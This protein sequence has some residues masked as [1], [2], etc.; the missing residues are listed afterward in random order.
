ME[1]KGSANGTKMPPKTDQKPIP[2]Y[3]GFFDRSQRPRHRL[4]GPRPWQI[5][6]GPAPPKALAKAKATQ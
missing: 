2:K 6:G 5:R 1:Q 4:A 3:D